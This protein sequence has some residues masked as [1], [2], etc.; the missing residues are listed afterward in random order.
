MTKLPDINAM[1]VEEWGAAIDALVEEMEGQIEVVL[2]RATTAEEAK[3]ALYGILEPYMI[4]PED[5][6]QANQLLVWVEEDDCLCIGVPHGDY[7]GVHYSEEDRSWWYIG[8]DRSMRNLTPGERHREIAR[9]AVGT[10]AWG[11]P[12]C[13]EQSIYSAQMSRKVGTP[14][15]EALE[16][17]LNA[18]DPTAGELRPLLSEFLKACGLTASTIQ[19]V[20]A[21]PDE[22]RTLFELHRG[23][24]LAGYMLAVAPGG[25]LDWEE[26]EEAFG[27]EREKVWV[28]TDH[29]RFTGLLVRGGFDTWE[30]RLPSQKDEDQARYHEELK[31]VVGTLAAAF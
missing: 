24:E 3:K 6:T 5:P 11:D 17:A 9:Y 1:D 19:V 29:L 20:D 26:L 13:V 21:S 12:E 14:Y 2:S 16:E 25:T 23:D 28:A 7:V 15:L 18:G 8:E 31:L 27:V 4:D 10:A 22:N 30:L